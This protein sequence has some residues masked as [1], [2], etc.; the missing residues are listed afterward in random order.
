LIL[1][2]ASL[3]GFRLAFLDRCVQPFLRDPQVVGLNLVADVSASGQQ[4]G[5]AGR[6]G[7]AE[8]IQDDIPAEGVQLDQAG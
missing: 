8:R 3:G 6:P 5:D 2:W 7:S 1:S 4:R